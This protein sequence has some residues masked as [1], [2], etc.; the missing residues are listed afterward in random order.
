VKVVS[1]LRLHNIFIFFRDKNVDFQAV[2]LR[3]TVRSLKN[4]DRERERD[5]R[6]SRRLYDREAHE[7]RDLLSFVEEEKRALLGEEVPSPAV[8]SNGI[9]MKTN[10]LEW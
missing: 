4:H 1:R 7:R 6:R 8:L 10:T 9:S 5:V 2:A 3:L